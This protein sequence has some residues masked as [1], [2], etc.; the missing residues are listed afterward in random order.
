M[1]I[2]YLQEKSEIRKQRQQETEDDYFGRHV[3]GVLKRLQNRLK[4][5]ARLGIEQVLM[6][7]EFP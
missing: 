6:D 7:V 4:T 2:H 5:V 3:E 1:L